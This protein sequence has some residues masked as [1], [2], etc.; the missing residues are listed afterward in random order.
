VLPRSSPSEP[1]TEASLALPT[2]ARVLAD[3]LAAAALAHHR[4]DLA[5]GGRMACACTHASHR[6]RPATMAA[7]TPLS[8]ASLHPTLA[9]DLTACPSSGDAPAVA[10]L[11][12]ALGSG[13]DEG[14]SGDDDATIW[15]R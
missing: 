14:K 8:F 6:P 4:S 9:P 3:E 15:F 10:V 2:A 12:A 7:P 1:A 13:S 11:A 5:V